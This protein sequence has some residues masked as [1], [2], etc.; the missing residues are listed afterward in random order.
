MRSKSTRSLTM[1]PLEGDTVDGRILKTENIPVNDL[2]RAIEEDR[3]AIERAIADV[4]DSGWLVHGESHDRFEST[5]AGYVG[6][7][8]CIGVANGTDALTVALTALGIGPGHSVGVVANAGF[9]ASTACLEVGARPHYIDV[10]ERS[11]NMRVD[12]LVTAIER[13]HLNAVVVTHLY[14]G[15]ADMQQLVAAC[16]EFGVRIIE[17]CAQSTG[18]RNAAGVAAGAFGD[19]GCFSF[20]P[21]KN[22]GALGDGG[23]IVTDDDDLAEACRR[24]RQYG[25]SHRYTV[26]SPGRNSRLDEIQAAVLLYRL[27][28]LDRRN[29]RR[30]EIAATY[31]TILDQSSTAAELVFWDAPSHVAH[32]AV[33][34]L[35]ARDSLRTHLRSAG[36][37]T[38]VHY[39]LSDDRQ[40]LWETI[41]TGPA[42]E[43]LRETWRALDEIVSLPCFPEMTEHEV[44]RVATAL[45]DFRP[46]NAHVIS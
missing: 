22:L 38:D 28:H 2:S 26:A 9:Y 18:A 13:E 15:L 8:H 25:W 10:D 32:L 11:L 29:A 27:S 30:R 43:D 7:R 39:P 16:R 31:A 19:I 46:S 45:S 34:R 24:I 35:S 12:S 20:Y 5:F 6:T 41:A 1:P 42:A 44:T 23:A 37:A 14:G 33:A 21:T 36:I 3:D 40:P 17:D 4:L